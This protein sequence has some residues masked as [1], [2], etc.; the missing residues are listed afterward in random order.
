MIVP[1]LL[2]KAAINLGPTAWELV[3]KLIQGGRVF[4]GARGLVFIKEGV[5]WMVRNDKVVRIGFP[6]IRR[7]LHG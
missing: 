4:E 6:L 5:V 3:R 7:L 1:N 2:N